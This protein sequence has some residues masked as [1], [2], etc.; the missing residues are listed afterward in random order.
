ML[1]SRGNSELAYVVCSHLLV[2]DRDD[3]Y[4]LHVRERAGATFVAVV[5]RSA[6]RVDLIFYLRGAYGRWLKGASNFG[7]D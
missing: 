7:P 5:R 4:L 2:G 6:E 3:R 1:S